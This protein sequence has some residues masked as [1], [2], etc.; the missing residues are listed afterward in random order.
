MNKQTQETLSKR[1]YF[2]RKWLIVM[3][4]IIILLVIFVIAMQIMNGIVLTG[5]AMS[6]RANYVLAPSQDDQTTA[7]QYFTDGY[8]DGKLQEL[9]SVYEPY[10]V[11]N[12][13]HTAKV[14]WAFAW[15]WSVTMTARV[16][17]NVRNLSGELVSAEDVVEGTE[18]GLEETPPAWENGVYKVTM[19]KVNGKWKVSNIKLISRAKSEKKEEEAT[20]SPQATA[21]PEAS[22]AQ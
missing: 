4:V 9:R 1:N 8:I 2:A 12:F 14:K 11:N 7:Q 18:G 3:A 10:T 6:A 5:E 16:E 20:Q 13:V 19:V 17:E 21:T 15:P 22:A